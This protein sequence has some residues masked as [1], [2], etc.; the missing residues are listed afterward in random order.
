MSCLASLRL[1]GAGRARSSLR[2]CGLA[3]GRSDRRAHAEAGL[4]LPAE[5]R[6]WWGWHDGAEPQPP[7]GPAE[8][9]PDRAFLPLAD[10]VR[11]CRRLRELSWE[12]V[13]VDAEPDWKASW[14][15]LDNSKIPNLIDCAVSHEDPVPAR[16]FSVENPSAGLPGVRSIGALV[17]VWIEAVDCGAWAYNRAAATGSTTA[18]NC[19]TTSALW[20]SLDAP[21]SADTVPDSS[22][23]TP[24]PLGPPRTCRCS[25]DAY[26]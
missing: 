19:A 16:S 20:L 21:P 26:S 10:A 4:S 8:V 22:P 12:V 9:G 24:L 3:D 25:I 1:D 18:R 13:P 11:E 15:P 6:R 17:M 2:R 23:V 7:G 14:L 5:A